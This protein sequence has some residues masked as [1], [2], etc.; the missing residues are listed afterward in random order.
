MVALHQ[1]IALHGDAEEN[2]VQEKERH[3]GRRDLLGVRIAGH[4]VVPD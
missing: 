2:V 3:R 4:L 1:G